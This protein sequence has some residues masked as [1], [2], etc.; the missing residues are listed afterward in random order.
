MPN[1]IR[2]S[3]DEN[4]FRALLAGEIVSK[5]IR[6]NKIEILL[7]DIGFGEMRNAIYETM[8]ANKEPIR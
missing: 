8:A 2:I 5:Q 1:P 7:S 4:D 6:D 3:L